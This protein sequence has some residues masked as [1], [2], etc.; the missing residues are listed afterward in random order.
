[1]CLDKMGVIQS[2]F[3]LSAVFLSQ[4]ILGLSFYVDHCIKCSFPY[5]AVKNYIV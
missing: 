3:I 1:M 2:V 4:I 5:I